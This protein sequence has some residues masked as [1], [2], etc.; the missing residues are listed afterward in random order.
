VS[1]PYCYPLLALFFPLS[2]SCMGRERSSGCC[3]ILRS[4]FIGATSN[5]VLSPLLFY[6]G[7]RHPP[8]HLYLIV[9]IHPSLWISSRVCV[10]LSSLSRRCVFGLSSSLALALIVCA[11]YFPPPD[12]F[13][14]V[15]FL[16]DLSTSLFIFP[17]TVVLP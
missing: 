16:S 13:R 9:S 5:F 7:R 14:C 6:A 17:L 15:Y 8:H 1:C 12:P 2:I 3:V 10:F 4:R 11:Y